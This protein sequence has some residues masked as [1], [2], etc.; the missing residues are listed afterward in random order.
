MNI[1]T[2]NTG[3]ISIGVRTPIIR[4]GND[5]VSIIVNSVLSSVNNEIEEGDIIGITESVVAR[6][7]GNYVTINDIVKY[8]E[9]LNIKK[10]IVLYEPI[11]SRNRFSLILKAF[12]RYADS[13]T[14]VHC[15]DFDQQGN[16]TKIINP[17]T[18][19]D[20]NA[21]YQQI[22]EKE[23]CIYYHETK[24]G[25]DYWFDFFDE[26]EFTVIDARCHP[27]HDFMCD[28]TLADIMSMPTNECGYNK[29]W[30]LLGSNKA[31]EEKLKL[32]PRKEE[33]EELVD[34]I[35]KLLFYKTGKHV[36][37]LVYGDGCFHSPEI[38]G[39]IGSSINE[40]ADPVTCPAYTKGLIGTPNEIKI[41]AFAD[42]KYKDLSG[43]E[44][45]DAI[46]QEINS[47]KTDLKG[48]MTS[49]GTTPRRLT[50]LLASLC[51]LTT[52][53]GGKGTPCVLIRNYFK[54]FAD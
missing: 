15:H 40:F 26:M 31:D 38:K 29:D 51:D 35:Q 28:F 21:Y 45:D 46:K 14:I 50:D 17:F 43:K 22:C 23:N 39:L 2:N 32:F 49:Q 10:K 9:R 24:Y 8:L 33:A 19:I 54:T 36:D 42:G 34:T 20:V 48:K 27:H 12:A 13:V 41:K 53:S 1:N 47:N 44:L 4:Q 5:L 16:P 52:G 11:M 6:S 7:Q 25:E 18:G 30:G 3:V 37:V